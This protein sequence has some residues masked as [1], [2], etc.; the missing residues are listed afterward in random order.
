MHEGG[1]TGDLL[2]LYQSTV[3]RKQKGAL[4]KSGRS[5]PRV[6]LIAAVRSNIGIG[7]F[8]LKTQIIGDFLS[9]EAKYGNFD[10]LFFC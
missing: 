3:G 4:E 5:A 9:G 6:L 7:K 1:Y 10:L 2:S 8:D